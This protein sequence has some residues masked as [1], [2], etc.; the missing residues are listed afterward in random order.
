MAYECK[1][2]CPPIPYAQVCVIFLV[3]IHPEYTEMLSAHLDIQL[4]GVFVEELLRHERMGSSRI[5]ST[6]R[7][8]KEFDDVIIPE[9]ALG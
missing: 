1:S 9:K 2:S 3:A 6:G 5:G 4:V 7:Q 8:L